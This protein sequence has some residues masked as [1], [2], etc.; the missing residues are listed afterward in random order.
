MLHALY[1]AEIVATVADTDIAK[2]SDSEDSYFVQ[3]AND[4]QGNC[5]TKA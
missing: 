5:S 3:S 2:L 1:A 4:R